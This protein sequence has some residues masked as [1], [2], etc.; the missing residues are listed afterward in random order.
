MEIISGADPNKPLSCG[1]KSARPLNLDRVISLK[2]RYLN[3][4]ILYFVSAIE[5]LLIIFWEI[6]EL[7]I[8]PHTKFLLIKKVFFP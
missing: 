3:L 8:E 2:Y 7:L 6:T 1:F 5:R 4:E